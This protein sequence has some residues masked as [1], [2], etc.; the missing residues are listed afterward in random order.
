MKYLCW[1]LCV[2]INGNKIYGKEIELG[3][4]KMQSIKKIIA[5]KFYAQTP[6]DIQIF[7]C[8]I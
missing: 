4:K 8:K 7:N 1:K 6:T 2:L 5:D 3:E